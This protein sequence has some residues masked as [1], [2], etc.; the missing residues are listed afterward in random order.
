MAVFT[1]DELLSSIERR[2]F[3]P[4][5][6]STFSEAEILSIA[7][8]VL[9]NV[10][11][12]N[13]IAAREEYYVF[14]KNHTIVID[15]AEY[16]I[17]SRAL[18]S[19]LRDV[20]LVEDSG[21]IKDLARLEPE[22][23]LFTSSGPLRG[24]FIRGDKVVID[25]PP[26]S[27]LG[28]LRLPFFAQPGKLVLASAGAVITAINT[29]TNVIT[30]DTIPSTWTTGDSFDLISCRGGHNY[31]DMDLTSTAIS[32]T[33]ITLPSLPSD[34]VVGDYVNLAEESS[35]VQVPSAYR[36]ALAQ[37]VAAEIL[38]AMNQPSAE[39]A[40]KKA[41]QLIGSA[42]SLIIPR[43]RGS[44]RVITPDLWF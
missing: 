16:E 41:V 20:Q 23:Q 26:T 3:A 31:R 18:G 7:D 30:V 9:L 17:P 14:Y 8:E 2:S 33:N 15:Q 24:Y 43:V 42:Q 6:Q 34:L 5:N 13:I 22:H 37:F 32:G 12:P 10:I 21:R 40:M 1:A 38:A 35:L 28:T 19:V 27:A 36:A 44:A 29:S 11:V 25:R 39:Q 4:A